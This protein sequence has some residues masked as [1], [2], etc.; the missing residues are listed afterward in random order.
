M[1]GGG[2]NAGAS[3]GGQPS[4]SQMTPAQMQAILG[5]GAVTQPQEIGRAHV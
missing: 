2:Q 3:Q 5:R 4:G 1:A